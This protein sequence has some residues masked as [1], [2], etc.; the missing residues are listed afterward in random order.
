[1]P[2]VRINDI[3]I[4]VFLPNQPA[5][6]GSLVTGDVQ[7]TLQ[8]P[9]WSSLNTVDTGTRDIAGHISFWVA[10]RRQAD[11][12][13]SVQEFREWEPVRM[14]GGDVSPLPTIS[15]LAAIVSIVTWEILKPGK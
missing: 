15:L 13:A 8:Y 4:E 3:Y 14:G 9:V 10:D 7:A 11:F 6:L 12:A 1:L 5:L 2:E